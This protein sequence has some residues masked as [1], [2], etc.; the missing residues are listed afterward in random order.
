MSLRPRTLTAAVA[1]AACCLPLLTGCGKSAPTHF[2]SLSNAAQE[3]T[4]PVTGPCQSIG[5]G[6]VDFPAYLDR[7]QIVTRLG[8]NQMHLAE[9]DQWAEPLRDNFQRALAE[10]LGMLLCAKPLVTYPWP[11]GGHPDKQIVIQVARFDGTLGQN[12]TLRA[13][14]SVVDADG[15]N[16]AWRSVEYQEATTGPGYDALAAAQSKLVEKFAKDVADT[17]RQ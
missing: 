6:P 17:L 15:N 14:W 10:N 2:F 9:F 16:L 4:A 12:A 8:P 13:S 11:V 5:I 7:S 1:V 3:K